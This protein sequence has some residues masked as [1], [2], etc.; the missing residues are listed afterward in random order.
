MK[1]ITL[2]ADVREVLGKKVEN[3]R[4][5][6]KV[7][8]ILYGHKTENKNLIVDQK[9]LKDVLR[10]GGSSNLVD[11]ELEKGKPIKV[12]FQDI[13][14]DVITGDPIHFDL[15][16][17]NMKEKITTDIN[18]KYVGVSKAVKELGGVLV[19]NLSTLSVECLPQFLVDVIEVNIE[20][21][22]DFET[23]LKIKDLKIPEG[24]TIID[25]P[26]LI[27]A[28]VQPPRSDEELKALD[29]KVEDKIDEVEKVDEKKADAESGEEG[30]DKVEKGGTTAGGKE[31][32]NKDKK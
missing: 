2:P 26:E 18:L 32:T 27:V 9:V 28:N 23:Q 6:G 12:L 11:L 31:E 22:A 5:E 16:Q 8:G 17:V 15:L 7:P 19:K 30:D 3:L 25:S 24:M 21:L 10:Q 4:R 14:R 1:S 29:E 13:Q 20:K